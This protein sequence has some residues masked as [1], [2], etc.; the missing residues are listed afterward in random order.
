M[1]DCKFKDGLDYTPKLYLKN[2]PQAFCTR[3][4][5][6]MRSWRLRQEDCEPQIR[7]SKTRPQAAKQKEEF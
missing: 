4:A 5:Q 1:K 6:V 7:L 2:K 3:W